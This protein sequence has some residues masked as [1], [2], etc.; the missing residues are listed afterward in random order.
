MAGVALT[1]RIS[2]EEAARRC[3]KKPV[4][5]VVREWRLRGVGHVRRRGGDGLLGEVIELQV[6]G[7]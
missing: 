1:D 4:L 7:V 2:S 3:G 6:P 5:M